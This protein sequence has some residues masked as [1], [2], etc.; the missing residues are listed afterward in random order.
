M[1]SKLYKH[2]QTGKLY[3][4]VQENIEVKYKSIEITKDYIDRYI[5]IS[6]PSDR[7]VNILT[8]LEF[9]VKEIEKNKFLVTAPSFRTTKDIKGKY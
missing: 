2:K 4:L 6:I 3:S 8:S 9:D 7:I 1:S 5:G